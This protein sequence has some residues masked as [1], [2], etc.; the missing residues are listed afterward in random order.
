MQLS[1]QF[2]DSGS[3]EPTAHLHIMI[4]EALE[5]KN[6]YIIINAQCNVNK[7]YN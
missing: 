2:N 3:L 1:G 6:V 4:S 7:L 5:K